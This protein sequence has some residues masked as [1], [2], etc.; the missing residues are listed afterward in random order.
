MLIEAVLNFV[1]H[2]IGIV[3]KT[4]I[5]AY[6][7]YL[8]LPLFPDRT[9]PVEVHIGVLKNH[10][11]SDGV[12]VV[13]LTRQVITHSFGIVYDRRQVYSF[14]NLMFG[15]NRKGHLLKTGVWHNPLILGVSNRSTHRSFFASTLKSDVV[16]E[17]KSFTPKTFAIVFIRSP[18]LAFCRLSFKLRIVLKI[19]LPVKTRSEGAAASGSAPPVF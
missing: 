13:T 12:V 1:S 15:I 6:H 19:E 10:K 4:A 7:I 5:R 8:F 17:R 2:R 11:I 3:N 18:K 9:V 14:R 16:C